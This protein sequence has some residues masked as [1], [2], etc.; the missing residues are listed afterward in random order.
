MSK[1]LRK[2][3]EKFCTAIGSNSML[4]QGAGGNISWKEKSALWVK[5]SGMWMVDAEKKDIFVP[6]DLK[7]IRQEITKNNYSVDIQTLVL[8]ELR[9][10]IETILHCLMPHKVV[11]H[12]H[13]VEILPYLVAENYLELLDSILEDA[14]SFAYVDYKKPGP[15]LAKAISEEFL[16]LPDTQVLFLQNHGIVIGGD[17]VDEINR[18]LSELISKIKKHSGNII[19]QCDTVSV[20]LPLEG[21]LPVSDNDINNLVFNKDYFACIYKNWAL[22]PDHVV[23][24]GA[25]AFCYD[26]IM[27]F[28]S[29]TERPDL[30][31]IKDVGV[32]TSPKFSHAKLDQLRCYYDVIIRLNTKHKVRVLNDKEINELLNWDLEKYRIKHAK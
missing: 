20:S 1:L 2:T 30:V 21:Y 27:S 10:S 14:Y 18:I 32:Y 19:D 13:A 17:D 8:S 3:V 24:L 26:S 4:V 29:S 31:F 28:L 6:V 5:A 11:L 23:F 9:P 15:D 25:H 7:N 16:S 22:Y 12:V